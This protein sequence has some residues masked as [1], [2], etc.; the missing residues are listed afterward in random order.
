MPLCI[1]RR[2]LYTFSATGKNGL[3]GRDERFQNGQATKAMIAAVRPAY[4]S[5]F[6][7][8]FLF[9]SCGKLV[10]A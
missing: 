9:I 1:L 2:L 5:R 3:S 7:I 4:P 8:G 6:F 10:K